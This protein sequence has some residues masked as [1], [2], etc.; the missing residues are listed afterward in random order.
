MTVV[1]AAGNVAGQPVVY[2]DDTAPVINSVSSVR[3]SSRLYPEFDIV[4][5]H[6]NHA[7]NVAISETLTVSLAG[8]K[9]S[10]YDVTNA[11]QLVSGSPSGPSVQKHM[12]L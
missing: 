5:A 8:G 6:S 12:K 7:D 4:V 3:T 2:V 9:C 10:A 1:D 11:T